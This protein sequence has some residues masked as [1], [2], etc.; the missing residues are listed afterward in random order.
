MPNVDY[1]TTGLQF[2]YYFQNLG[3]AVF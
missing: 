2:G 3:F 1:L